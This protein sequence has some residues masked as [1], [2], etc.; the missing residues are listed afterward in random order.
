MNGWGS[1]YIRM[2]GAVVELKN[3]IH[4]WNILDF[5][6][7]K[8]SCSIPAIDEIPSL[9]DSSKVETARMLARDRKQIISTRNFSPRTL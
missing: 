2:I 6:R 1:S 4:S 7:R 9:E 3:G 5:E 8:C